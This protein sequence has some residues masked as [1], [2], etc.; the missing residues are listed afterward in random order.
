[1]S[2]PVRVFVE[3]D[4]REAVALAEGVGVVEAVAV[5]VPVDVAVGDAVQGRKDV[6]VKVG[7]PEGVDVEGTMAGGAGSTAFTCSN[8]RRC[9]SVVGWMSS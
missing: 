1:V 3:V 6:A 7:E 9:P 8:N 2:V 4:V 5:L